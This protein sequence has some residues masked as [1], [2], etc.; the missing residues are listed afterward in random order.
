MEGQ[1]GLQNRPLY[2]ECPLLRDVRYHWYHCM[3]V[4]VWVWV[5]GVCVVCVCARAC[6]RGRGRTHAC[7]RARACVHVRACICVWGM[8]VCDCQHFPSI[9]EAAV[10]PIVYSW[11]L[12]CD[13]W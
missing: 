7:V 2:R 13:T 10:M 12:K 1:L 3:C 8:H 6:V 11:L 5:C 9:Q 4:C